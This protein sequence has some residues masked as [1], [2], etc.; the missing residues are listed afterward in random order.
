LAFAVSE[1]SRL[2]SHQI[3]VPTTAMPAST[4]R[5]TTRRTD[6]LA[7]TAT[8]SIGNGDDSRTREA[9]GDVDDD[10]GGGAS[11]AI[12]SNT[13]GADGGG[14]GGGALRSSSATGI[15]SGERE[16]AWNGT[17]LASSA[18]DSISAR[19]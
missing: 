7:G 2:V 9:A 14:A 6:P 3:E 8:A 18:S 12:D 10:M 4:N 19:R 1:S 11:D 13:S 17:V 15:G 5:P 16:V